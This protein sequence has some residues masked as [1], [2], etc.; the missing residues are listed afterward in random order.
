C[1]PRQVLDLVEHLNCLCPVRD[2]LRLLEALDDCR[3]GICNSLAEREVR[4]LSARASVRNAERVTVSP[5]ITLTVLHQLV[6]ERVIA[7]T[8]IPLSDSRTLS[9]THATEVLG[10]RQEGE[11]VSTGTYDLLEETTS[12]LLV[13]AVL[14]ERGESEDRRI[15][16]LRTVVHLNVLYDFLHKCFVPRDTVD[17]DVRVLTSERGSPDVVVVL[18]TENEESLK[19]VLRGHFEHESTSVVLD[20]ILATRN[21][22]VLRRC[23]RVDLVK[24]GWHNFDSFFWHMVGCLSICI[25]CVH[26]YTV[27]C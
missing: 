18:A 1:L 7:L 15:D 26:M 19:A 22:L 9:T 17:E 21:A 11:Q 23:L 4:I 2:S 10:K 8:L 24:V 6:C 12:G 16:L 25:T 13:L 3:S 14:E 5:A 20:L 27:V